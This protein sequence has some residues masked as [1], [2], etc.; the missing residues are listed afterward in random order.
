MPQQEVATL[1]LA[2]GS[3]WKIIAWDKRT[4]SLLSLLARTMQL[5]SSSRAPDREATRVIFQG[6]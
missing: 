2:D 3:T 4:S 1:D 6:P 5:V